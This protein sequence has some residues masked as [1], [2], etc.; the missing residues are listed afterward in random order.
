MKFM[1]RS[2][3]YESH[4]V[5]GIL[6][7]AENVKILKIFQKKF[8]VRKFVIIEFLKLFFMFNNF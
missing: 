3:A 7:F 2:K 5:V 6:T 4:A 1:I 8:F